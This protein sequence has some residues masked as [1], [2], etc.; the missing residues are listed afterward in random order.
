MDTRIDAF[1][2]LFYWSFALNQYTEKT[3]PGFFPSELITF[4]M[5]ICAQHLTIRPSFAIACWQNRETFPNYR[6]CTEDE[7]R[8][9]FMVRIVTLTIRTNFEGLSERLFTK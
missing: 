2:D 7:M 4:I 1:K 3:F 5:S 8:E 9:Y 6:P